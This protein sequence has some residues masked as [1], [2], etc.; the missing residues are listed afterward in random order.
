MK[1]FSI[2]SILCA[3]CAATPVQGF[4]AI[5]KGFHEFIG[6]Q[7]N[8]LLG[9]GHKGWAHRSQGDLVSNIHG[10]EHHMKEHVKRLRGA[11]GK[12][13]E[14]AKNL[15]AAEADTTTAPAAGNVITEAVGSAR[16]MLFN[17]FR[18]Y[19]KVPM[20]EKPPQYSRAG[21][22]SH[23][24]DE[25]LSKG[26]KKMKKYRHGESAPAVDQFDGSWSGYKQYAE[27]KALRGAATAGS[28][29]PAAPAAPAPAKPAGATAVAK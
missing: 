27:L 23:P 25:Y 20:A 6:K 11:A 13:Q 21:K 4:E 12:A 10:F 15:P 18:S 2:L 19:E 9:K 22:R 8:Q 29:A 16:R 17:V 5:K 28:V 14:V 1:L 3:L 26:Q 7:R 24:I